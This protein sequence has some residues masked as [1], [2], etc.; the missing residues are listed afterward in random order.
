MS[1]FRTSRVP[2]ENT[3]PSGGFSPGDPG[4]QAEPSDYVIA[5]GSTSLTSPFQFTVP[6]GPGGSVA[7]P[8]PVTAT[9]YNLNPAFNG[10]QNSVIDNQDYLDTN[11]KGVELTAQKRFSRRWQMTAGLTIGK[12][13]GGLNIPTQSGQSLGNGYRR[14]AWATQ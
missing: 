14:G 10:L 12:N 9:V 4:V 13:T 6:N 1:Y 5:S 8:Q 11:Y 3:T 7:S 2:N